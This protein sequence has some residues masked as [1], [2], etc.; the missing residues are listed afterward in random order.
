MQQNTNAPVILSSELERCSRL[1]DWW[2]IHICALEHDLEHLKA[3]A[4]RDGIQKQEL[5]E[6]FWN[7]RISIFCRKPTVYLKV[8][9]ME[10]EALWSCRIIAGYDSTPATKGYQ[11]GLN[12]KNAYTFHTYRS[13]TG[14]WY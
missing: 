5:K 9:D 12:H 14:I 6:F 1:S 13:Q 10:P 11:Y 2:N 3:Y 4:S 8:K 7:M